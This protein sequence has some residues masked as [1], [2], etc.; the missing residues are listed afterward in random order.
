MFGFRELKLLQCCS[1]CT[2][3]RMVVCMYWTHITISSYKSRS[4]NPF[5]SLRVVIY[6]LAITKKLIKLSSI[7]SCLTFTTRLD[8]SFAAS[9]RYIAF[10]CI[11]VSGPEH[12]AT[13][14]DS[15]WL[16]IANIKF[17]FTYCC[18]CWPINR[19]S[20]QSTIWSGSTKPS[21]IHWK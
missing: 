6:F 16:S 5:F 15:W 14:Y 1:Q 7:Y 8:A 13:S 20:G 19:F 11:S 10:S 3:N 4:L 18:Y 12:D 17:A 21:R 2:V 9:H